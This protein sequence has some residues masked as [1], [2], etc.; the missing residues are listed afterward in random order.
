ME[1]TL[2]FMEYK[3]EDFYFMFSESKTQKG[4]THYNTHSHPRYEMMFIDEGCVEY[5]VENR[6]HEL[7]KGDVLLVKS[8]ILHFARTIVAS[9]SKRYC[10]GFF[11]ESIPHGNLAK[12]IFDKGEHFVLG[13]NSLFSKLTNALCHKL[14][15][16]NTNAKVF[17]KNLMDSLILALSEETL[18]AEEEPKSSDSS[19]KRI[20]DYIN[21]NLTTIKTMDD[22]AD[23]LFFSKS[24]LGHLFKKETNMG[25][26]EYVRNKKVV[27][28]HTLILN[29]E[30]PTEIYLECGFSNYPSFFRAY[31][32]F[33]GFSPKMKKGE[34]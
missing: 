9:P 10:I 14:E 25:I 33:F 11:P 26:M 30:K 34:N 21:A 2:S 8:G 15:N 1:K 32:A 20:I 29:G 13:E 22:I 12:E 6:R 17:T 24:Y 19:L 18:G 28:A 31:R 5:L 16:S 7:K 4:E 23:A 27:R 3:D